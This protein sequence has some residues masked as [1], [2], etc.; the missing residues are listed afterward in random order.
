MSRCIYGCDTVRCSCCLR[1]PYG[2]MPRG[3]YTFSTCDHE[4]HQQAD[5]GMEECAPSAARRDRHWHVVSAAT[6]AK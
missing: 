3:L 1:H 6:P 2:V 4:Q 5:T